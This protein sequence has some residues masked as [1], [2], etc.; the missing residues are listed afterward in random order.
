MRVITNNK[1][2]FYNYHISD[3]YEAGVVLE[4]CEVKS[5]RNGGI[6]INESFITI[7]SGELF[8]KNAFIKPYDKTTAY[9]P[10]AKRNRKLLLHKTEINKIV[11]Q[12]NVK[13]MT[14]IPL[15]VYITDKGLVKIEIA[16]A[17]GK[18]LYDKRETLKINTANRE[19]DRALKSA[20]RGW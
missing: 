13:G 1:N 10:D 14:I 8:L 12:K 7:D 15:K 20:S 5:V 18:K 3:K 19:I 16:L 9:T 11:K 4:G 2:A 17:K 6:S